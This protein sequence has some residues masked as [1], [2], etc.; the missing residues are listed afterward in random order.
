MKGIW[1]LRRR[2]TTGGFTLVELLVVIAIIGILAAVIL[3]SLGG[4]RTKAKDAR[5]ISDI[6]QLRSQ[7]EQD[8]STGPNYNNSFSDATTFKA[9]TSGNYAKL[10]TD[11]ET[12]NGGTLTIVND[13]SGGTTTKYA[14]YGKLASS[15]AASPVYFCA[16]STGSTNPAATANT[17]V[18]CP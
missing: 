14:L 4:A 10:K 12:T 16:D 2:D 8:N 18:T 1:N 11:I 9:A 15:P 6:N 3:V 17:T 13:Y 7:I 5:I